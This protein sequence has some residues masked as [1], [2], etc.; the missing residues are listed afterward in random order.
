M[1][2]SPLLYPPLRNLGSISPSD[3]GRQPA[4]PSFTDT[5]RLPYT[6]NTSDG[7]PEK[8]IAAAPSESRSQATHDYADRRGA[9]EPER[10]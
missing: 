8:Q 6:V 9:D 7:D 1:V 4:P 5:A 3:H 10:P 2:T